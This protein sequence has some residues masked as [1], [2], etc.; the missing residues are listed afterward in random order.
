MIWN[1]T[2]D[3]SYS[4]WDNAIEKLLCRVK[5]FEE[6]LYYIFARVSNI[7]EYNPLWFSNNYVYVIMILNFQLFWKVFTSMRRFEKKKGCRQKFSRN[8]LLNF[9]QLT[10]R[11]IQVASATNVFRQPVLSA[12]ASSLK[13]HIWIKGKFWTVDGGSDGTRLKTLDKLFSR[14]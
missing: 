5:R 6:N 4:R 2:R 7:E 13:S 8:L 3:F 12:Y 10:W 1:L 11:F 14:K 9:S